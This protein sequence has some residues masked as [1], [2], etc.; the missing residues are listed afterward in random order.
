MTT[1]T[2]TA[3]IPQPKPSRNSLTHGVR[4]RLVAGIERS[5]IDGCGGVA[6]QDQAG[7]GGG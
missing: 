6:E 1:R 2:G 7:R 3:S 5:V 4:A